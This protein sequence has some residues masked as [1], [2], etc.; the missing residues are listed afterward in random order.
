MYTAYKTITWFRQVLQFIIILH[1]P[2]TLPSRNSLTDTRGQQHS[3]PVYY[4]YPFQS[5]LGFV[6]CFGIGKCVFSFVF[7][8]IRTCKS[9][10]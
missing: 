7:F 2:F 10:W 5:V 4:T 3:H 8:F 1:T 6:K 9:V